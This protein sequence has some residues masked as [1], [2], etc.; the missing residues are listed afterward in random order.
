MMAD[1]QDKD[2]FVPGAPACASVAARR[3]Y[4][5]APETTAGGCAIGA[6]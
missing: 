5:R 2:A 6:N 3:E 4:Y 1:V